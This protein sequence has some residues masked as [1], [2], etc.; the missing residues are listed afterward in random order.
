MRIDLLRDDIRLARRSL[1]RD[2]GLSGIAVLVLALGSGATTAI[3]SLVNSVL[4]R[5]LAFRSPDATF[6]VREGV[7][8]ASRA[9]SG[10]PA[11]AR[12]FMAWRAQTT[13]F[14]SMALINYTAPALTGFGEPERLEGARV[15]AAFF[16]LLGVPAARGRTFAAS[17]EAPGRDDV[18]VVS[19]AFWRRLGA[20]PG[21]VG[22][23]LTIDGESLEVVGVLSPGFH[24]ARFDPAGI[25]VSSGQV[26]VFR[27]WPLDEQTWG[28]TGDHNYIALARLRAGVTVE[29]AE[30]DLDVVQ[31][32]IAAQL[33]G[34]ERVTLRAALRPL[35]DEIVGG[36]RRGLWMV[37]AAVGSILLIACGNVSHL[38]LVRAASRQRDGAVRAALG[39]SPARLARQ[40]FVESV[41]LAGAGGAAGT[42]IA[43]AGLRLLVERAPAD[44]P[45]LTEVSLDG[46]ALAVSL[47][48][49]VMTGVLCGVG[50]AWRA[51][52][53][54]PNDALSQ[55]GRTAAE[56]PRAAR[57]RQALVVLEVASSTAIVVIAALLVTSFAR[58]SNV[59]RGF[60]V[61][62]VLT[63]DLAL[64]GSTYEAAE[65]RTQLLGDLAP[66]LSA[67][68][69]VAAAGF[70]TRLP[71][72]GDAWSDVVTLPGDERPY[73]ERPMS[74]YRAIGGDYFRAMGMTLVRGRFIGES[75]RPRAV[76]VVSAATARR[77]WPGRNPIGQHF[78]RGNPDDPPFEV[79]GVSADVRTRLDRDP[80]TMIYVPYWRRHP[81]T[82]S[83]AVRTIGEPAAAV[84]ALKA[85]VWRLDPSLPI[86]RVQTLVQIERRHLAGRRFE[87]LL[88]SLFGG[89][90]LLLACL[91][92]YSCLAFGVARRRT[93]LGV[94]LALGARPDQVG[95][96]VLRQGLRP[97]IGGIVIGLLLALGLGR[98]LT[99]LLFG[100]G[101]HDPAT[102]AVAAGV[103]TLAGAA[104]CW[105]PTRRATRLDPAVTLRGE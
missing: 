88:V 87:T 44:L 76:A 19:D 58:L 21:F 37:L 56:G 27:P 7:N 96:L 16:D 68:P 41:M 31:A 6:V 42:A 36:S 43:V 4:L 75:D 24:F 26:E 53:A 5:P 23:R 15:S 102:L 49:S 83:I 30:A 103:M 78:R 10:L 2:R 66:A 52:R 11:N 60:Q 74:P 97:V 92:A 73:F 70:V 93:E 9:T 99:S 47:F 20:D 80:G 17:E 14:E 82:V 71:L 40:S 57:T 81:T 48:A 46:R 101:S 59:D 1:V 61:E 35:H 3:F 28:L 95:W 85:A 64:R 33:T 51:R 39:A 63:A 72:Q 89:V 25:A 90:S 91:G 45:R 65:R 18:I 84:A 13:A 104:A 8:A 69:G 54:N 62:H 79:V 77:L 55:S 50:P 67:M 94:R 22:R 86:A 12:H 29:R 38:L 100:V 34:D 105:V 32:R 98:V